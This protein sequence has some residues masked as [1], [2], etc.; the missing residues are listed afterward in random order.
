MRTID[1][2]YFFVFGVMIFSSV[3]WMLIYVLNRELVHTD[4]SISSHPSVTYLVPAYNE[5]GYIGDAIKSLLDQDYS[6]EINI[7]AINDG[8]EDGTL[9]EMRRFKDEIEILDKENTGKASSLNAALEMVETELVGVM[10]GDS[11]ADESM[12]SNMATYFQ[13]EKVKGVTPAMKVMNPSSWAEKV[14]WAEFIYQLFLR[15][16]F[17]IFDSQYVM[18]GPGSL[19]ETDYLEELG[20][21][22]ENTLTEDMEVAFR[23]V[24]DGAKLA[25]STNAYVD[26]PSPPTLKGLLEQRT[27]W[28][29]GYIE[30]LVHYRKI[31]FN[32]NYGNLGLV[33]MPMMVLWT[34]LLFFMIGHLF[35]RLGNAAFQTVQTYLLLGS[36]PTTFHISAQSLSVFHIFYG[37]FAIVSIVTLSLSLRTAE[38]P[39]KL[40]AR[41]AHYLL[42]LTIYS[43]LYLLFWISAVIN[44][45]TGGVEW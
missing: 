5:E 17:A 7:I 16:L 11:I 44:T 9:E 4:P 33:F 14:M 34:V 27:R 28:Y 13:R 2:T 24:D 21:W 22:D 12:V 38:E 18:P 20:G 36:L 6:G 26:T 41:K 32:P 10:D 30:N 3:V 8:S 35:F 15:K 39:V 25:N 1:I 42:F 23:M 31:L 45:F 37:L 29:S 40:W 19:Y 43:P